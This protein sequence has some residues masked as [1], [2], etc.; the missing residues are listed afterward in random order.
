[1]QQN[2]IVKA[3]GKTAAILSAAFAIIYSVFKLLLYLR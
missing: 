1:M 2:N 3:I